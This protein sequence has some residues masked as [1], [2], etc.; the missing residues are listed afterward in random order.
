MMFLTVAKTFV[1]LSAAW[2]LYT[3]W[4]F[5][6]QNGLLTALMDLQEPGTYLPGSQILPVRHR[7]TGIRVLDKHIV[8]M[9]GLF[10][11]ALEG[12]RADVSLVFLE[13]VTQAMATCV[14]V[15]VEALRVGN[16]GKWYL[17]SYASF[18]LGLME[19][20][21]ILMLTLVQDHHRWPSHAESRIWS[22]YTSLDASSSHLLTYC[23][24]LQLRTLISLQSP[25]ASHPPAQHYARFLR[26]KCAH[27]PAGNSFTVLQLHPTA[28][29]R[30]LTILAPHTHRLPSR[31]PH[32]NI[33]SHTR[34][35]RAD[36]TRQEGQISETYETNLRFRI[37]YRKRRPHHCRG[38]PAAR[39]LLPQP[40]QPTLPTPIK[41]LKNLRSQI[42]FPARSANHECRRRCLCSL[43][44]GCT[45]WFA[46]GA[47]M[48]AYAEGSGSSEG[49]L[50][51]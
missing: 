49:V 7:Y 32:R 18:V 43:A 44:V 25:T 20:R 4:I 10:W 27:G 40:V 51:L 48:G 16:K 17:T 3:L 37:V 29:R 21:V 50:G 13:V 2:A 28:L 26:P 41:S 35:Q 34:N 36:R 33:S 11:P 1:L 5:P 38:H 19:R 8:T 14:L 9:V 45:D 30:S 23:R 22:H 42:A 47:G 6:Y 24:R 15:T 12:S 46:R 39:P 31:P